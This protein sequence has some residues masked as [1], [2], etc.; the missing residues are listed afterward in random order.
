MII[1]NILRGLKEAN[2]ELNLPSALAAAFVL[3]SEKR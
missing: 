3:P 2:L 1:W